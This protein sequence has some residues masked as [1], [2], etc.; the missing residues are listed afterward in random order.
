MVIKLKC[1][2]SDVIVSGVTRVNSRT[3]GITRYHSPEERQVLFFNK[4]LQKLH[5]VTL[6]K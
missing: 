1:K 6:S 2:K 3:S 5:E 4:L